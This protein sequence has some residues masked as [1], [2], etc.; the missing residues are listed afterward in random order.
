MRVP[1]AHHWLWVAPRVSPGSLRL[2][3]SLTPRL[4]LAP[5]WLVV[6]NQ[7][8]TI[9]SQQLRTNMSETLKNMVC[10]SAQTV[11]K[12]LGERIY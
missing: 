8:Q 4:T 6:Y 11:S 9:T 12:S 10:N 2:T 3:Y 7:Q 5:D 1:A